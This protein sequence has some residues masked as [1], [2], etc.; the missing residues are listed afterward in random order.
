MVSPALRFPSTNCRSAYILLK[1]KSACLQCEIFRNCLARRHASE[2]KV[3]CRQRAE[4]SVLNA[5]PLGREIGGLLLALV[6]TGWYDPQT[7]QLPD[8]Q[9]MQLSWWWI[10]G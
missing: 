2:A 10:A 8:S 5:K 4:G 9:R 1:R 6:R 3:N 7:F